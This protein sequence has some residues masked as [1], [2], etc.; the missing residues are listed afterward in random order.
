MRTLLRLAPALLIA[1]ALQGQAPDST[2]SQLAALIQDALATNPQL[3][4]S[5]AAIDAERAKVP[6]AG[7]LPDPMV[8]LGYQNDGFRKLT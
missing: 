5:R 8:S 6:Q 1:G 3:K 7:A 2:D 4:A